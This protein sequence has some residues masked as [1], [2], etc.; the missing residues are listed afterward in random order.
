MENIITD[1]RQLEKDNTMTKKELENRI[2]DL[3]KQTKAG[4]DNKV[5]WGYFSINSIGCHKKLIQQTSIIIS[6]LIP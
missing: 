3:A 1:S 4:G 5:S 6:I 2:E